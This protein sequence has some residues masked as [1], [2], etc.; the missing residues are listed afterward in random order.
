M[1]K[2][3]LRFK[4]KDIYSTSPHAN[5]FE[6][7]TNIPKVARG[8]LKKYLPQELLDNIDLDRISTEK[9]SFISKSLKK[10]ISDCLIKAYIKDEEAYIIELIEHQSS[11][12]PIMPFRLLEYMV[13]IWRNYLKQNKTATKLPLI[14][15]IVISN[16]IDD[17]KIPTAIHELFD[18]QDLAKEIINFKY[19]LVDLIKTPAEQ[20][21]QE[22]WSDFLELALKYNRDLKLN[23]AIN[24]MKEKIQKISKTD[25]GIDYIASFLCYNIYNQD[26]EEVEEVEL[27]LK[28][29]LGNRGDN[30]VGSFA[31]K[32]IE[33]GVQIGRSEGV[34]I[35]E[36][37]GV[38]IGEYNKAVS[39]A[40]H[41]LSENVHVQIISRAT[42]LSIEEV[43]EIKI[44]QKK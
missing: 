20:F 42:G 9:T 21:E 12:D 3:N 25:E 41:L 19:K 44:L 8:L 1:S 16:A 13:L 22:I 11:N 43:N 2:K 38:Q 36:A 37:R 27:S 35:G 4:R 28:Q 15:P 39:T 30:M 14:Y 7:A 24:K 6:Y 18:Y 40:K 23:D 32:F 29:I 26:K 31:R 10:N 33:E 5:F 17:K 34:Q